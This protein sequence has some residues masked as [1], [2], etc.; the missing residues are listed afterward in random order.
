MRQLRYILTLIA[1]PTL[2][3]CNTSAGN[4]QQ[5]A[6][7]NESLLY[8]NVLNGI[9]P[10]TITSLSYWQSVPGSSSHQLMKVDLDPINERFV[11]EFY[12]VDAT[13]AMTLLNCG[14]AGYYLTYWESLLTA[15]A[16]A[17]AGTKVCTKPAPLN[18]SDPISTLEVDVPGAT[19]QTFVFDSDSVACGLPNVLTNAT[20]LE[21]ILAS[22]SSCNPN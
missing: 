14:T 8:P 16:Q 6:Q 21:N 19:P 5:S 13:G 12:S 22:I 18:V 20:N 7:F 2:V 15:L 9:S 10:N 1:L 4:G 11:T 3:A 17:T